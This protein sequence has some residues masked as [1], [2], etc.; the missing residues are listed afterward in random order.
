MWDGGGGDESIQ[1]CYAKSHSSTI[2]VLSHVMLWRIKYFQD[3][4][5]SLS[6]ALL[7]ESGEMSNLKF[8]QLTICRKSFTENA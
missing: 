5:G 8:F 1:M 4:S 7:L 2:H 3:T 6:S